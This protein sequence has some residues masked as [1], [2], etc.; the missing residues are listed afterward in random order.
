MMPVSTTTWH[1]LRLRRFG[2]V[3]ACLAVCGCSQTKVYTAKNLPAQWHAKSI[4]NVTT[5]DMTK[6]SSATIPEDLIACEDVLEVTIAAGTQR[7]DIQTMPS[8]VSESGEVDVLHVG[9]VP[10]AGLDLAEAEAAITRA[11]IDREIYRTPHVTVVMKRPKVNRI[12][13]LGAVEK[14][15]VVELRNGNSDLLQA[16]VEAGNLTK[17]AGSMVEIHHP[18]FRPLNNGNPRIAEGTDAAGNQ[19]TSYDTTAKTVS[20]RTLKVDLASLGSGAPTNYDL[21]DGA[22]VRVE[23]RDPP[24][25]QVIGLVRKPDRYEFPLGKNMRL[26]DAI[27]LAG[28]TSNQL[29]DKVFII[30]R[31]EGAEPMLVGTSIRKAKRDGNE[32]MLLEP[33][34]TVS[35]EQ[36]PGTVFLDAIRTV[37]VNL[38]G[39]LF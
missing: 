7:E 1:S 22:V 24:A 27:A 14:P 13:V 15:G 29:A 39:A 11:C 19:L 25:L 26:T 5:F 16:L 8:R 34:D 23:K 2:I 32:N 17:E 9:R 33:G 20:S 4:P 18:G 30:R 31:R 10:V 21:E 35:I 38:G 12:T 6:L 3:L 36:T 37:G 28:G